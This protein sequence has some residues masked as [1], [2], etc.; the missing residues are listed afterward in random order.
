MLYENLLYDQ[1]S[2]LRI[3]PYNACESCLVIATLLGKCTQHSRLKRLKK[4]PDLILN[5]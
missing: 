4:S 3:R 1:I 5:T 2:Y